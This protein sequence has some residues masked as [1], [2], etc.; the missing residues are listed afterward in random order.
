MMIFLPFP[1]SVKPYSGCPE[2]VEAESVYLV[3]NFA[4]HV[5]GIYSEVEEGFVENNGF[6]PFVRLE[7]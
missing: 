4:D 2:S 3:E 6:D 1:E 7:L 5:C